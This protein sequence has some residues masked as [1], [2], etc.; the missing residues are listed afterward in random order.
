MKVII[1]AT[2]AKIGSKGHVAN[3]H[4]KMGVLLGKLSKGEAR[5]VRKGLRSHG[6]NGLAAARRAA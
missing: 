6:L 4:E 2:G 3:T 1:T 5:K